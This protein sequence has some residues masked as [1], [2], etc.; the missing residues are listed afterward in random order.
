MKKKNHIRT[1]L[2]AASFFFFLL[3]ASVQLSFAGI[4]VDPTVIELSGTPGEVVTGEYTVINKGEE[5]V[6]VTIEPVDWL[7][8]YLK[9]KD[10]ISPE[11]WLSFE[12]TTYELGPAEVKKIPY[13]VTVPENMKSEEAA[14]VYFSFMGK[15]GEQALRTRLGVIFYLA[16]TNKVKIK[17]DI[18]DF[19][20]EAKP[21]PEKE[22]FYNVNFRVSIKNE[23]NV[24]IRPFGAVKIQQ[25][26]VDIVVLKINPERGIYAGDSDNIQAYV[27]EVPLAP[28]EYT[29][30]AEIHCDMYG[31]QEIITQKKK[32]TL[33]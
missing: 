2:I 13:T 6:I 27:E 22:N 26:K 25:D 17:A 33:E 8:R 9:K 11:E 16:A 21:T 1:A 23:G 24:H 29:V 14:Q 18:E 7:K 28:G 30:L 32:V 20:F 4:M 15:S 31:E 12:E 3:C 5:P 10:T 19:F